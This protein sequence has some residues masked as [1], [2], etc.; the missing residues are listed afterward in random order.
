MRVESTNSGEGILL[1]CSRKAFFQGAGPE[2][3]RG[4]VAD[5]VRAREVRRRSVVDAIVAVLEVGLIDCSWIGSLWN[6]ST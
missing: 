3:A 2:G 1:M 5:I 6:N 4:V